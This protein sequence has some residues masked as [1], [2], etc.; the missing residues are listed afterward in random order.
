MQ[1]SLLYRARS[2]AVEASKNVGADIVELHTGAYCERALEGSASGVARELER[3]ARGAA[4][5]RGGARGARVT[6]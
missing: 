2:A 3:I 5:R 6:A 4:C 1:V